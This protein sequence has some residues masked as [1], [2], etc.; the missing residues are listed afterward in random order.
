MNAERPA[1]PETDDDPKLTGNDRGTEGHYSGEEYDSYDKATPR[2]VEVGVSRHNQSAHSAGRN[3]ARGENIPPE[4]GR[5]A[6]VDEKTGEVHGSGASAGGG[7]AM[8]DYDASTAG[9]G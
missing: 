3:A 5:R 4:A 7:N 9:G 1:P 8:E 6:Y 2:Y